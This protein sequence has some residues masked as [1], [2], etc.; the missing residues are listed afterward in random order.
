[1]GAR[2]SGQNVQK[3]KKHYETQIPS[4]N[5][6]ECTC[7][8]NNPCPLGG[9]CNK[10]DLVYKAKILNISTQKK[11]TYYGQTSTTLKERKQPLPT[12]GHL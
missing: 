3:V 5:N 10:K 7:T 11:Y 1:M 9:T 4:I 6:K 8:G 2:L 12:W